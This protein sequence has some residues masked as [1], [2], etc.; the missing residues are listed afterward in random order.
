MA[1][2][3]GISKEPR[4]SPAQHAPPSRE[5]DPLAEGQRLQRFLLRVQRK[6]RVQRRIEERSKPFRTVVVGIPSVPPGK[7]GRC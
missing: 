7:T 1:E 5:E 2:T 3:S 4:P 6:R